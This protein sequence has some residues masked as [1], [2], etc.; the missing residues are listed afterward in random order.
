MCDCND[1]IRDVSNLETSSVFRDFKDRVLRPSLQN[2]LLLF[3][4]TTSELYDTVH[5]NDYLEESLVKPSNYTRSQEVHNSH[6]RIERLM[7]FL[8]SDKPPKYPIISDDDSQLSF[9]GRKIYDTELN[10]VMLDTYNQAAKLLGYTSLERTVPDF[11]KYPDFSFDVW[12]DNPKNQY[13]D[14]GYFIPIE[15]LD[16]ERNN[17][18]FIEYVFISCLYTSVKGQS[19]LALNKP[20][21]TKDRRRNARRR[22]IDFY[23]V[24]CDFREELTFVFLNHIAD[25]LSPD[26][27]I[28]HSDFKVFNWLIF[29]RS[30]TELILDRYLPS[31]LDVRGTE[32]IDCKGL[33]I[34]ATNFPS[35]YKKHFKEETKNPLSSVPVSVY[36][37]A[38]CLAE[39][40]NYII[41]IVVENAPELFRAFQ[42][43]SIV[44]DGKRVYDYMKELAGE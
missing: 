19:T 8:L 18:N 7:R 1:T 5:T 29:V 40:V 28:A 41:Q 44:P 36:K 33:L 14:A 6:K 39:Y 17:F 42:E 20:A 38:C 12:K 26:G 3:T 22:F 32:T 15:H 35:I 37:D 25:S 10:R 9:F 2:L 13:I 31:D 11:N 27:C 34:N 21:D 43:S 4:I 30:V 23:Y 16:L 24:L